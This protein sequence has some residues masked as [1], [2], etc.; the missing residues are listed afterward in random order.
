MLKRNIAFHDVV[1]IHSKSDSALTTVLNNKTF[2][3]G[4]P[5]VAAS[6]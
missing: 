2:T 3:S 4:L 6:F 5:K 1:N